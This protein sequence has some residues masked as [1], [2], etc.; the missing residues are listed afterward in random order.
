MRSAKA[1]A[2]I[3]IWKADVGSGV[4]DVAD[5][6]VAS[7]ST[8]DPPARSPA[9]V[10]LEMP[11]AKAT[12]SSSF[13]LLPGTPESARLLLN[14]DVTCATWAF[15]PLK[16]AQPPAVNNAAWCRTS[17]DRFILANLESA[18]IVPNAK[19]PDCSVNSAA[20]LT[21]TIGG[22]FKASSD[23]SGGVHCAFM[24]GHTK[25]V[26]NSVDRRVWRAS[27]TR[28]GGESLSDL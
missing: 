23:Q 26:S 3:K 11:L 18:K 9:I 4:V 16:K 28:A 7:S 13:G 8:N 22:V 24:D 5:R 6:T 17:I 1:V 25:F 27:S 21:S 19:T 15:E 2:P 12:W 20:I 14:K 10:T